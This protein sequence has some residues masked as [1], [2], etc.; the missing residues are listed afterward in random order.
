MN[1][2]WTLDTEGLSILEMSY[3]GSSDMWLA[4]IAGRGGGFSLR[5]W[6]CAVYV[7]PGSY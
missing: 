5:M 4:Q 7:Q 6:F 3:R 1:I 2:G